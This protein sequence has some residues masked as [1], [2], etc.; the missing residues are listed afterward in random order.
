[1][2]RTDRLRALRGLLGQEQSD[3]LRRLLGRSGHGTIRMLQ[4]RLGVEADGI[5]GQRTLCALLEEA[6][7]PPVEGPPNPVAFDDQTEH[8]WYRVPVR[9][10]E[11]DPERYPGTPTDE[12]AALFWATCR[13]CGATIIVDGA[14]PPSEWHEGW[15]IPRDCNLTIVQDVMES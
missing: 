7:L 2:G 6:G 13:G 4:D 15:S 12:R 8:D 9:E 5:L 10:Q 14:R 3:R 1:M 11:A